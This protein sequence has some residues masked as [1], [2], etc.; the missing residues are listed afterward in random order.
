MEYMLFLLAVLSLLS[1]VAFIFVAKWYKYK[2]SQ[3]EEEPVIVQ[4]PPY[5]NQAYESYNTKEAAAL[6][7]KQWP[8]EFNET[9]RL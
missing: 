4:P 9:S 8:P 5:E 1:L 3:F 6:G 7:K 2:K